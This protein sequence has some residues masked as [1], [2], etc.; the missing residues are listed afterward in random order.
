MTAYVNSDLYAAIVDSP[1]STTGKRSTVDID[2][3]SVTIFKGFMIEETA[4]DFLSGALAIFAPDR[5]VVPFVGIEKVRTTT[6]S[7]VLGV[8]LQGVGKGGNFTLDD[9]KKAIVKVMPK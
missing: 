9:N 1:L 4:D 3:N 2:M 5:V 6:D 8:L 7:K